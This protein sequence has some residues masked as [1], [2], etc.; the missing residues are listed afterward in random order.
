V[1]S[2]VQYNNCIFITSRRCPGCCPEQLLLCRLCCR[3]H[4]H[5]CWW[6]WRS[7]CSSHTCCPETDMLS[8]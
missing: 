2:K 5:H 7:A 8:C 1:N 4:R 6:C 3:G